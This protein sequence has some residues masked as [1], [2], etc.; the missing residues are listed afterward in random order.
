MRKQI[1]YKFF[2]G[3]TSFREEEQIRVW[4]EASLE[5]ER[6]FYKERKLYDS[7][8]LLS[9]NSRDNKNYERTGRR[10]L[11]LRK[12]M[13]EAAKIAAIVLIVLGFCYLKPT[14]EVISDPVAMQTITVPAGQRVNITL[15]DG[16]N[17]WLNSRSTFQ[18]S[19]SF[20]K[21]ER[22]VFLDGE[23]YL[24]VR[25]DTEKKFI[26]T[27]DKG[28]IEV[29]GTRFNVDSYADSDVFET[30]LLE[31]SLNVFAKADP[32]RILQ[33][34][35]NTRATLVQGELQ[36]ERITDHDQFSWKE[37]LITFKD[38]TFS[39]IMKK[40]EKCYGTKIIID[41]E[42]IR[43]HTYSG[44]FRQA[45][46]VDYAL[47]VLQREIPVEYVKDEESYVITIR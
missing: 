22:N 10:A 11:P 26:V 4:M 14:P 36:I 21:S 45:D 34:T 42:K 8:I 12:V 27:T 31:G 38:L 1:L 23:A 35:S 13:V 46:G 40:F 18:Y 15:P 9:G 29:L 6:T 33:L 2:E 5:N 16:T 43:T 3:S 47:R 39:E 20:N 24:E 30:S 17:V 19:T 7:I 28:D 44:K 32:T 25:K 37:G 41:N